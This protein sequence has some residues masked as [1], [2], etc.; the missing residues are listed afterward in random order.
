ML[1]RTFL[2]SIVLTVVAL[3][4]ALWLG[5]PTALLLTAVL[6]VL[7]VSLSF[8]NAVINAGV[9]QRMS[10]FWQRIF[11]TVG[12]AIAVFGMRLVFP[13]LLVTFTTGLG[14]VETFQLALDKPEDY[15]VALEAAHPSIAAFGGV[16]LLMIFLDFVFE[17]RDLRWLGP[18]ESLLAKAGR[19]GH[20]SVVVTLGALLVV[21]E[22]LAEHPLTVISAGVIGVVVYLV[23]KGLG[24]F[25]ETVGGGTAVQAVGRAA[26]FLFLYLEVLDASFSFDGVVGAFAVTQNIFIIAAGLGVGAMFV[27]SITVYLVNRG[28]LAEYVFLEHGAHWAVGALG[29]ILLLTV[30]FHINEVFTG[31]IGLCFIV[32]ALLSS[33]ARNRRTVA[34]GP[35]PALIE[36][37]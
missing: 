16:F 29:A 9:L 18:V 14:P 36:V 17:E 28:T 21:A 6:I 37:R 1:I 19:I 27:R 5:G 15:R 7:E 31:F 20:A 13:I 30:K 33:I 2:S 10:R 23:V 26:F 8:D 4:A 12:V 3:V 11:L 22:T 25:F 34:G 24:D 32:A 35:D